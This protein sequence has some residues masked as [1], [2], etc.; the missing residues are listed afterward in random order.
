MQEYKKLFMG[1][2]FNPATVE[3]RAKVCIFVMVKYLTRLLHKF[4]LYSHVAG[5][6]FA[7]L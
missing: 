3:M 4:E 5:Y 6:N 1:S 2:A 7:G